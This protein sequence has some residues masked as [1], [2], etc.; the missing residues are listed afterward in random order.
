MRLAQDAVGAGFDPE[1]NPLA[2]GRPHRFRHRPV[3]AVGPHLADPFDSHVA[4]GAF[5]AEFQNVVLAQQENV[6]GKKN[7]AR[8]LHFRNDVLVR[9]HG[10]PVAPHRARVIA[11]KRA[12]VRASARR[13]H[14]VMSVL[15][16]IVKTTIHDRQLVQ[17]RGPPLLRR[18]DDPARAG[19]KQQVR[20]AAQ[21]PPGAQAGHQI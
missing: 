2:P 5:A 8:V 11:A 15:R 3:H 4:G 18:P 17:G 16:E 13:E 9:A 1:I 6:I 19:A 20:Q 14:R 21:V 12:M 7:L 10:N